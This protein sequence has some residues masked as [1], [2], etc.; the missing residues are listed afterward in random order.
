MIS[1]KS[2]LG[3]FFAAVV[4][5]IYAYLVMVFSFTSFGIYFNWKVF[6][7]ALAGLLFFPKISLIRSLIGVTLAGMGTSAVCELI[8][9]YLLSPPNLPLAF[10][11]NK[12]V[13]WS[14]IFYVFSEID[15]VR[16]IMTS[17]LYIALTAVVYRAQKT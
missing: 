11:E 3:S 9:Y 7:F 13:S 15:I 12:P 10:S 4:L 16:I 14:D 6:L 1:F 2:I 5:A 17:G 8:P